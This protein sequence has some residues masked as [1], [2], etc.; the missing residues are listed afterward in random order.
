[1]FLLLSSMLLVLKGRI[2]LA[3][4]QN[5]K[6]TLLCAALVAPLLSFGQFTEGF[7]DYVSGDYVSVVS[8]YFYPWV[9]GTEGTDGDLQITDENAFE[10][11]NSLKVE[12]TAATGGPGDVLLD[13]AQAGATGA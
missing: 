7:E 8:D 3:E 10:S 11:L 9:A 13:V 2:T 1:M 6:K 4:T 12:Q 5:M